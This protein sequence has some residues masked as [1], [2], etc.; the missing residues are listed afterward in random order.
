MSI[1][2]Q[3]QLNQWIPSFAASNSM[4]LITLD[5]LVGSASTHLSLRAMQWSSSSRSRSKTWAVCQN[6][7]RRS[8]LIWSLWLDE[9]TRSRSTCVSSV[10]AICA[11]WRKLLT[12]DYRSPEHSLIFTSVLFTACHSKKTCKV[13]TYCTK[14]DTKWISDYI[15]LY[16]CVCVY[17]QAPYLSHIR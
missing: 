2:T 9:T 17:I 13:N 3:R 10:C 14:T 7:T 16:I 12:R 8:D 4:C 1:N 6:V 15:W 11:N 5:S